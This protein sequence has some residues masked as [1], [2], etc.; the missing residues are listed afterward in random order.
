M[1]DLIVAGSNGDKL[2]DETNDR[3]AGYRIV[4]VL[5][6]CMQD[7]RVSHIHLDQSKERRYNYEWQGELAGGMCWR[8]RWQGSRVE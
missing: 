1:N 8:W 6:E 4:Y 7:L 5:L 2:R 3:Y